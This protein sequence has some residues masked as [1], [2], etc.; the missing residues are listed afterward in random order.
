MALKQHFLKHKQ[1]AP[2]QKESPNHQEEVHTTQIDIHTQGSLEKKLESISHEFMKQISEGF[3]A[4]EE[5]KQTMEQIAA[6][7][8]ESAGAAEE[9]LGAI[10]NIKNNAQL[11][12]NETFT[13]VK[14]VNDLS[15]LLQESSES[16]ND[17][18]RGMEQS[19][20]SA[21]TI[22]AKS[23]ALA[24]TS[25]KSLMQSILSVT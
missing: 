13:I 14:I 12:E 11:M 6:A 22:V 3:T 2:H 4:I 15:D 16:I 17:T 19:A 1:T 18:K 25:K 21:S 23:D 9:S 20:T 24:K 10:T 5:L 8:E 7:A